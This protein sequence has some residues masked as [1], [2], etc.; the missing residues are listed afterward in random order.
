[1]QPPSIQALNVPARNICH[2]HLF[3][4]HHPTNVEYSPGLKLAVHRQT[5]CH[6]MILQILVQTRLQEQESVAS[7]KVHHL[8]HPHLFSH[9]HRKDPD[10]LKVAKDNSMLHS[11]APS[12]AY[13][14]CSR[15]ASCILIA[16]MSCSTDREGTVTNISSM[17]IRRFDD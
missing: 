8:L 2:R 14:A 6:A 10:A 12:D 7:V 17:L 13:L 1:M 16:R 11:F 9:M 5:P 15:V 4:H 3:L